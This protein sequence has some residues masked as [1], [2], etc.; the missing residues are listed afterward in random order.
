MSSDKEKYADKIAKLLRKAEAT[1]VAEEAQAFTA[2][3]QELMQLY[4]IDEELLA[5]ARG[6]NDRVAEAIIEDE[7][8]YTGIYRDALYDVGAAVAAAN[9]V[10]R[11]I[12][13][14]AARD[15]R[16]ATTVLHL[17]GFESD[18]RRVQLLNASVQIQA[19]SAQLN[20][21]RDHK[22]EYAMYGG[23]EK[24]KAR[25]EF[26][27]G[28]S[29]GL[30]SKLEEANIRAQNEAA[31]HAATRAEEEDETVEHEDAVAD[32]TASVALVIQDKQEKVNDWMDETYG[33]RIRKVSRNYASG[34][35]SANGAG[36]AA[37]RSAD[38]GGG[39]IS[40]SQRSIGR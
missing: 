18:V 25:R 1:N 5:R 33:G 12:S 20:W 38:M 3:A 11:L 8:L 31:Q 30:S 10:R 17:I 2:K 35:G 32:A 27:F 39:K 6:E 16:P 19:T 9:N 24:F 29:Q 37:G 14:R 26:I 23:M 21:W 28:F 15:G 4:A 36:Y 13:K 34:G 22:D 7:I 40:G